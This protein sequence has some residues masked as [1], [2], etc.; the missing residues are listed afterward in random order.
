MEVLA[1]TNPPSGISVDSELPPLSST[2]PAVIDST[3]RSVVSES[4]DN[5]VYVPSNS[6]PSSA[7]LFMGTEISLLNL[8]VNELSASG[9]ISDTLAVTVMISPTVKVDP[10]FEATVTLRSVGGASKL[11]T[12]KLASSTVIPP[13]ES[14]ARTA[15]S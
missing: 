4:D 12:V 8:R 6:R 15:I 9:I 11:E 13:S 1:S 7:F 3:P 14:T 2:L 5:I 10:A